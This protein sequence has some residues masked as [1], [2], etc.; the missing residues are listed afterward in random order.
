MTVGRLSEYFSGIAVKRLSMVEINANTSNQHE[1]NGS[2]N[3]RALFG[4]DKRQ[5]NATFLYL[6]DDEQEIIEEEGLMT[7]YNSR[8]NK[9][10]RSAEY[11]FYYPSNRVTQNASENDLLLLAKKQDESLLIII[12]EARSTIERQ[13]LWLMEQSEDVNPSFSLK[14]EIEN[15]KVQLNFLRRLILE[16]IGIET[17]ETDETELEKMLRQFNGEFPSSAQLARYVHNSEALD[18]VSDPDGCLLAWYEKEYILFRTLEEHFLSEKI[19]L[20]SNVAEFMALSLSVQNRRKSRAGLALQN[21]LE[22]ILKAH[23]LEFATQAITEN[24]Y[25]PDFLFPSQEKY[26]DPN[27]PDECLLMLG[28]KTSLKDRWRQIALEASRIGEKHLCTLEAGISENQTN[29]IQAANIRLVVPQRYHDT[30]SINQQEWLLNLGEFIE[31]TKS[32]QTS[33]DYLRSTL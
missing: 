27:F 13:I 26:H 31:H 15:D 1:F 19:K 28:A 2:R 7:W 10:D 18:P 20:M 33:P 11:R 5:F 8:A 22:P 16:K 30:F 17:S 4:D 32:I 12:A 29:Q 23:K 9:P 24:R 14:T 25:K 6:A 3:L 21:H